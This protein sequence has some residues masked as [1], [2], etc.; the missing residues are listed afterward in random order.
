MTWTTRSLALAAAL[1]LIVSTQWS[2]AAFAET[3]NVSLVQTNDL[4]RMEED[5][6]RGGFARLAAVVADEREKGTVILV[7]SGDAISPSLLSGIDKGAHIID[8][9]NNM[10]FDVV[11]PGNHEFDFGPDVFQ[12]R[13]SQATF[14]IVSSNIVMPG[15]GAPDNTVV[16]HIVDVGGV[17][18][19]FYGLTTEDT[20]EV[21]SPGDASF[22][23]AVDTGVSAAQDLRDKGADIVIAVVHTPIDDD[24]ALARANGA[25]IILSGH[26]EHVMAYFD[27]RHVITESGAQA[28]HVVVTDLII[29]RTEEDGKVEISWEPAFRIIDTKGVAPDPEIAEIVKGYTEKLDEELGVEIGASET[30]LDSRRATVRSGE[31]AI[32]NLIADAMRETMG[33]DV[34]ITNGGGIRGDKEYPADRS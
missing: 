8:I 10:N 5:D 18:L 1:G 28:E 13:L 25:D 7:H 20:V 15:G 17:K 34:A 16:D 23:D 21:S 9:M 29:E 14:P 26:D 4:D 19:G 31:A 3:I 30:P 6:G 24:F 12:E 33:S 32:G 2:P 22:L 11:V 27:G